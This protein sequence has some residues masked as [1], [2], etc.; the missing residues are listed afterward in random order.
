MFLFA[1]ASLVLCAPV[2]CQNPP[3]V[4]EK[5]CTT[6][7]TTICGQ[8]KKVN[9]TADVTSDT[10]TYNMTGTCTTCNT[11][12]TASSRNIAY[13]NQT[14][15]G[16]AAPHVDFSSLCLSNPVIPEASD[17]TAAVVIIIIIGI[18]VLTTTGWMVVHFMSLK[19]KVGINTNNN[20]M[21]DPN[22]SMAQNLNEQS[23][24]VDG[25]KKKALKKVK[26]ETPLGADDKPPTPVSAE[27]DPLTNEP[28]KMLK[29][30]VKQSAVQA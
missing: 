18:G 8:C 22:N 6:T 28:K 25:A 15:T 29:R 26:G 13:Q 16:A 27:G 5:D 3:P 19:K 2:I 23:L 10:T 20:S 1:L 21:A 17:N 11:D 30:R 7:P 4:G 9:Y 14:R 24:Q 12:F